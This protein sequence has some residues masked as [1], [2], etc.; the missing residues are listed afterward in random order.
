[1]GRLYFSSLQ[2]C[3]AVTGGVGVAHGNFGSLLLSSPPLSV[4]AH[5]GQLSA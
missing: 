4:L 5:A 1:M 2:L 3:Q